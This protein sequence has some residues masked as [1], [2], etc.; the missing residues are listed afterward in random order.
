MRTIRKNTKN[1]VKDKRGKRL[2]PV[3]QAIK[4]SIAALIVIFLCVLVWLGRDYFKKEVNVSSLN[5]PAWL[6]A[7]LEK[8]ILYAPI[9]YVG[10]F[11]LEG[12][13]AA[14]ALIVNTDKCRLVCRIIIIILGVV[15]VLS[16]SY[17]GTSF[18]GLGEQISAEIGAGSA[19]EET[20]NVVVTLILASFFGPL[21]LQIATLG[22]ML[23]T[24]EQEGGMNVATW[25]LFTIPGA[26][27]VIVMIFL[28][29]NLFIHG[30]GSGDDGD[31]YDV[32]IF[33]R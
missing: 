8:V 17:A 16:L 31:S 2:H 26:G 19:E 30:G 4:L 3:Q 24:F 18:I 14:V 9:I 20:K 22:F 28:F 5:L 23:L 27:F 29:K 1:A 15:F 10:I 6:D 33:K 13:L 21:I 7:I 12:I 11:A 32:I 25:F